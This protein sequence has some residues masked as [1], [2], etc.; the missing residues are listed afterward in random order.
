MPRHGTSSDE[1]VL[2]TSGARMAK[3]FYAFL[4]YRTRRAKCM[5]FRP[6]APAMMPL[7]LFACSAQPVPDMGGRV[8]AIRGGTALIGPDL[9]QVKDAVVLIETN[10]IS[11]AGRAGEVAIPPRAEIVDARGLTVLPGFIDAHVHIALADPAEVVSKG[12]TTARDL[13]WPG[14]IWPLVRRSRADDFDGP[15]LLAAGQ[16]LTADGGYPTRAPWAPRGTG[17]VVRGP[18]DADSAVDEQVENGAVIIKVALNRDAGPTLRPDTLQAIV[19]AAHDRGVRVTSHVT[20]LDELRKAVDAGVDEL[21]HIPMSPERIP[22]R[23]IGDMV[24]RDMTVVPTLSIRF[25]TDQEIAIDNLRRFVEAGGRVVYGTDLGNEG[26]GPGID[27]REIEAMRRAGMTERSIIASA[28]VGAA[29]YMSLDR[30]GVLA[31]GRDADVIA[32]RGDPLTDISALTDVR[33]VWRDGR[34][35]L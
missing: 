33:M 1:R 25:G 35:R 11:A 17:R 4:R 22:D 24:E 6:M 32:V 18:R 9:R 21:A 20:G 26:P 16:M 14:E 31:P 34:R 19:N 23:M 12:V 8:I 2:R 13:A 3:P 7:A 5:I 30:T 27:A 29:R 10:G 15:L 28:T